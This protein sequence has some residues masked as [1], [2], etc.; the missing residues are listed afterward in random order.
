MLTEIQSVKTLLA[1]V[2]YGK[3]SNIASGKLKGTLSLVENHL[4][5]SSSIRKEQ[6][7]SEENLKK[8]IKSVLT[9]LKINE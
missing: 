9:D 7:V 8:I 3:N 4:K 2:F 5:W 6:N 1:N